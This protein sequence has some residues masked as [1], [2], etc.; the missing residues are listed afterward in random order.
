MPQR[1]STAGFELP[2]QHL[3]SLTHP[4]GLRVSRLRPPGRG[5]RAE[6]IPPHLCCALASFRF[7]G[8]RSVAVRLSP[9]EKRLA[10]FFSRRLTAAFFSPT[11][12]FALSC[13]LIWGTILLLT[14][15]WCSRDSHQQPQRQ[16]GAPADWRRASNRTGQR[17]TRNY[18]PFLFGVRLVFTPTSPLSTRASN[19][20]NPCAFTKNCFTRHSGILPR[21]RCVISLPIIAYLN[22]PA[23]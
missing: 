1:L 11:S 19:S 3:H 23:C 15:T 14:R 22:D 20:F 7:R 10:S 2:Q 6:R 13:A 12:S 21:S 8:S 16:P 18:F 4:S 9:G 17:I 5:P